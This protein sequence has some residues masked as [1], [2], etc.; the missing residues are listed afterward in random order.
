MD[1]IKCYTLNNF[2]KSCDLIN[3]FRMI[4]NENKGLKLILID[5]IISMINPWVNDIISKKKEKAKQEEKQ[6]VDNPKN[7]FLIY[8]Q[9]FQNFLTHIS[10][11]QNAYKIQCFITINIDVSDR[12][13]FNQNSP[14]IFNAI[15][16]FIQSTYYFHKSDEENQIDFEEIKLVLN[17]KTN[18]IE[19]TEIN[20]NEN[21]TDLKDTLLEKL[22]GKKDKSK[23]I[24]INKN[25]WIINTIGNFVDTINEFKKKFIE[26]MKQKEE[27]YEEEDSSFT[28]VKK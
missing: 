9:V 11:L 12:I 27:E 20:Q 1:L 22:F 15:F 13:Y 2:E 19:L 21:N 18:K 4:S 10:L 6:S 23:I 16:P 7:I 14:R 3:N 17:M 25:D 5:D 24:K 26:K 28:Q 8:N